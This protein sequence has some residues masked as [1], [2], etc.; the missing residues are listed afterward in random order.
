MSDECRPPEGTPAGTVC[1]LAL[2]RVHARQLEW[3]WT[4]EGWTKPTL[5]GWATL[6]KP[7]AALGWRFHSFA[8]QEP[9][10]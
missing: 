4:G 6:A 7:M 9:S 8:G 10:T 2:E 5:A 3:T 1:V